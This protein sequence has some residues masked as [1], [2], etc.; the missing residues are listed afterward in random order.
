MC[1]MLQGSSYT[2]AQAQHPVVI[3]LDDLQWADLASL[4]LIQ[5][6]MTQLSDSYLLLISAYRDNE[7]NATHPLTLMLKEIQASGADVASIYLAPLDV[8][9]INQLLAE[10][11]MCHQGK[12]AHLA[13]L[14]V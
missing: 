14:Q 9:T 6:L 1:A 12:S 13:E 10:T 2:N 4:K 11:L 8:N 5:L 3:F 7:V